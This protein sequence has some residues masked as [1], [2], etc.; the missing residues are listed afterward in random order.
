MPL[1]HRAHHFLHYDTLG[2]PKNPPLL[3]IMGLAVSSRAW[4]R[5]PELMS[6]DFYVLSFDNRGT[7]GSARSGFAY[8]MSD[9][10]DDAAAV[11]E[12]AGLPSAH[13]FGISMGGMIAQELALRHPERVRS[14]ALGATLA[15]FRKGH[16]A[17]LHRSWDLVALNLGFTAAERVA[18]LLVSA[19]WEA[20]NPG[21][22]LEWIR[23][24]EPAGFRLAMA[25]FLA[26]ARHH[27]LERL[28]KL[29]APTLVI[30]GDADRLVPPRNSE[31]LAQL[32]PGARL[33]VL[34]G[35]GHCF[36]LEREEETV[37]ALR[38]HFLASEARAA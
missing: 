8:R 2:D 17:S 24:A 4:G 16:R 9:L 35:A 1:I 14:L 34:P 13:V 36:P 29:R 12:A 7:G 37:R 19:D 23:G 21:G 18:R 31:V 10:A 30:T 20:R 26:V 33:L 5:L 6:R 22:A 11:I 15:S 25:Q 27:T 28:A 38:E 32:I 3:L